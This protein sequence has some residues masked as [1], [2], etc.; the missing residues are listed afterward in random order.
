[1]NEFF[2]RYY[3]RTLLIFIVYMICLPF[4]SPFF[5]QIVPDLWSCPYKR[6]MNA[7]CPFCG[8]THSISDFC[9]YGAGIP[10][11]AGCCMVFI[12]FEFV[13]KLIFVLC[14]RWCCRIYRF[15][16]V[17]DFST[18]LLGGSIVVYL[19]LYSWI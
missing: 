2:F 13:K 19:F 7:P 14:D 3:Q 15:C 6:I 9:L 17:L 12:L 18:S 8:T 11:S 4:F 5:H 16:F 10:V 1:M